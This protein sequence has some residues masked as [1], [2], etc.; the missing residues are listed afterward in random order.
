MRRFGTR[1]A[2]LSGAG[3][4]LILDRFVDA[5]STALASHAIAPINKPGTSWT[6]Q[7]GSY[8]IQGNKASTTGSP[9]NPG[10]VATC[11]CRQANSTVTCIVQAT[12][13]LCSI[14]VVLRW[15]GGNFYLVQLSTS[16][17][18]DIFDW[19]GAAFTNHATTA[20]TMDTNPHTIVA[21][22]SGTTIT[23]TLDGA[24]QISFASASVNPT[25]TL[26]GLRSNPAANTTTHSNFQV[27]SP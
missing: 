11:D 23:A 13:A 24:N 21:Q 5:N 2:L 7:A 12:S 22:I 17:S 15:G 16:N 9:A 6:A 19:N 20:F 1:K 25:S 8:T 3:G 26:V 14:G 10:A 4:L 18:F 27:T